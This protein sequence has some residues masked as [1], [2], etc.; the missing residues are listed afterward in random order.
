MLSI[1]VAVNLVIRVGRRMAGINLKDA[2]ILRKFPVGWCSSSF[3]I[4]ILKSF[5]INVL[6]FVLVR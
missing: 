1:K 2:I 6:L 5:A 3:R 4:F